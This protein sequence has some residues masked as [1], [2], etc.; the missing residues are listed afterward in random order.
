ML[1]VLKASSASSHNRPQAEPRTDHCCSCCRHPAGQEWNGMRRV[2]I[3]TLH[4]WPI[5]NLWQ[6]LILGR[7]TWHR[8]SSHLP[9]S[10]SSV[11]NI[12]VHFL[13]PS[14]TYCKIIL[15][16][17][18]ANLIYCSSQLWSG[19]MGLGAESTWT[20]IC[21]I[22][23]WQKVLDPNCNWCCTPSPG[24]AH[25]QLMFAHLQLMFAHLQL[26]SQPCDWS[27]TWQPCNWCYTL[28][29]VV[30]SYRVK[31]LTRATL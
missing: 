29:T 14:G 1:V 8:W 17:H 26:V 6:Q 24:V 19:S 31:P 16:K 2:G 13:E 9:S 3:V 12:I 21:R 15:A 27:Q 4:A 11:F 25:L 10:V 22:Q 20:P 5:P 28:S 30:A 23:V 7:I 18:L